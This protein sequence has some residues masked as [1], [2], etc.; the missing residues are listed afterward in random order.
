MSAFSAIVRKNAPLRVAAK[1]RFS[2]D[3]I[4]FKTVKTGASLWADEKPVPFQGQVRPGF[5]AR[6]DAR[7]LAPSPSG[8]FALEMRQ[9]VE[10]SGNMGNK[11]A[12]STPSI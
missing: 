9:T 10:F 1:R 7:P 3:F 12:T 8:G 11:K 4:S 2:Y 6:S 5:V